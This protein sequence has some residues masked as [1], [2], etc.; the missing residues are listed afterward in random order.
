[1]K[2]IQ[3]CKMKVT[4]KKQLSTILKKM[5]SGINEKYCDPFI[6]SFC[7][8]T[9]FFTSYSPDDLE[10]QIKMHMQTVCGVLPKA[11]DDEKYEFDLELEQELLQKMTNK[12]IAKQDTY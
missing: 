12:D 1:M 2:D 5:G 11:L 6:P 8:P 7:S 10:S 4:Q 3:N 9:H